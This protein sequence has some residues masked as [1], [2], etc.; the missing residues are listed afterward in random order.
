MKFINKIKQSIFQFSVL[1]G[2]SFAILSLSCKEELPVYESPD[3]VFSVKVEVVEQLADRIAPPD[4]QVVR[5]KLTGE[6][7]YDEV[8][9]DTV[10]IKGTMRISWLRN[11]GRER[12][13]SFDEKNFLNRDLISNRKMMLL[14]GQQFGF[15]FFW[16]FKGDDSV[17]FPSEMNYV[18]AFRRECARHLGY[19]VICS[20]PEE[21][22]IEGEVTI[23]K[24]LEAISVSSF[25]FTVV[26]KG[27]VIPEGL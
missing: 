17:Y 4:A 15:Q 2:L 18:Y 13:I 14:P 16:N 20:D 26:G 19:Q 6:N 9:F 23:F 10:N 25:L 21:M 7:I 1:V 22:I 8:F 5:M 27:I 24:N 12:T 3:K 11:P